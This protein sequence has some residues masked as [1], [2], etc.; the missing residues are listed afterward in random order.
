MKLIIFTLILLK[1]L[2]SKAYTLTVKPIEVVQTMP[3]GRFGQ[4]EL[5]KPTYY[6]YIN[7][8]SGFLGT[9]VQGAT[10]LLDPNHW[11]Y[12]KQLVENHFQQ[13]YDL[14]GL[15]GSNNPGVGGKYSNNPESDGKNPEL[16]PNNPGVDSKYSNNPVSDDKNSELYGKNLELDYK[17]CYPHLQLFLKLIC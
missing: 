6:R 1:V 17:N 9:L 4:K 8:N 12:K 11:K 7:I 10:K 5:S 2:Q 3:H 16:V 15:T 14:L 13:K